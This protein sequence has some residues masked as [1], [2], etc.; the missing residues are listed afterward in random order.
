ML[1]IQNE[2]KE[3]A[4]ISVFHTE[5][6]DLNPLSTMVEGSLLRGQWSKSIANAVMLCSS[7]RTMEA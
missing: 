6:H 1:R 5:S 3:Y 2:Q 7:K 4:D